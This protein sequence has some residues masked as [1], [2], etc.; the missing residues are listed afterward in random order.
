MRGQRR[1]QPQA[2]PGLLR[3]FCIQLIRERLPR[4][5]V[6]VGA[7]EVAPVRDVPHDEERGVH[8]L[9]TG[10]PVTCNTPDHGR[11][12]PPQVGGMKTFLQEVVADTEDLPAPPYGK[13]DQP[14]GKKAGWTGRNVSLSCKPVKCH[15]EP[16]PTGLAVG[17]KPTEERPGE[18]VPEP[19]F[20]ACHRGR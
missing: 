18:R 20:D 10:N 11:K 13:A 3:F 9:R 16:A 12:P 17:C 14:R 1:Q 7:P 8:L 15:I 5:L 4:V 6:A 19:S 2:R